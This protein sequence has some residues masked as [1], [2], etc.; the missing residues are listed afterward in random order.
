MAHGVSDFID[1][2]K[3]LLTDAQYKEGMEL[4]QT[5]FNEKKEEKKLYVMTY[6]RPYTFV[7]GSEDSPENKLYL[8]FNKA[9]GIIQLDEDELESIKEESLYRGEIEQFIDK[10]ALQSFPDE[11]EME[12]EW[13]EF[14]VIDIK[15]FS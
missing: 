11:Y 12:L 1:S 3:E 10:D 13:F 8:A 9:T 7:S 5:L 14:P 6:L 2:V 15:P 4:C